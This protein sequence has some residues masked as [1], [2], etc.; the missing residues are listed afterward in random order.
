LLGEGIGRLIDYQPFYEGIDVEALLTESVELLKALQQVGQE[1]VA[2]FV[3]Q[4]ALA[5][6]NPEATSIRLPKILRADNT[7][8]S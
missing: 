1:Q 5:Q 2:D 6:A 3:K 4:L 8:E 7:S